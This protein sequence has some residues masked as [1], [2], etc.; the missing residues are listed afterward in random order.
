MNVNSVRIALTSGVIAA[1]ALA[2]NVAFADIQSVLSGGELFL[3]AENTSTAA[4]FVAG[5]GVSASSV[6]TP[7]TTASPQTAPLTLGF[8]TP[9][10]L[11]VS[12][13]AQTALATFIAG[14]GSNLQW[15]II[16]ANIN[17]VTDGTVQNSGNFLSILPSGASL[18]T[19]SD[20]EGS[21]SGIDLWQQ[22][23][24]GFIPGST[25]LDKSFGQATGY[26]STY[27]GG[28]AARWFLNTNNAATLLNTAYSFYDLSVSAGGNTNSLANLY[29]A[30]FTVSLASDGSITVTPTTVPLPAAVWLLGSGLLGLVGIGRRRSAR[31]A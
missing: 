8:T 19:N 7:Q 18:V 5:L 31:V 20:L 22:D 23:L 15:T 9:G 12:G 14:A 26:Y 25:A 2:S 29:K 21:F 6:F 4:T 28:N 3:V 11:S 17:G 13:A 10:S 1:G 30:G 16:G 24:N 27:G